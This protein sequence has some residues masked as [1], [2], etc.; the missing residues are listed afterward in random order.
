MTDRSDK[1][2][3]TALGAVLIA[4]TILRVAT[5]PA[6]AADFSYSP[7]VIQMEGAIYAHDDRKFAAMVKA[8][9]DAHTLRLGLSIGGRWNEALAI[10]RTVRRH[11]MATS[12]YSFCISACAAVWLVGEQRTVAGDAPEMHLPG[13]RGNFKTL[14]AALY[15]YF[16]EFGLPRGLADYVI[17]HADGGNN[18]TTPLTPGL[19][20]QFAL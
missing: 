3:A 17:K 13:Y 15:G 12:S 1:I 5:T 8:H 19:L 11:G 18:E 9:P 6:A 14:P 16:A 10:A 2:A 7:G 20:R 4:L